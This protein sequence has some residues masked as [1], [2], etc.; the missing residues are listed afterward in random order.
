MEQNLTSAGTSRF[1][2]NTG[3]GT[4]FF[5]DIRRI[6]NALNFMT[7]RMAIFDELDEKSYISDAITYIYETVDKSRQTFV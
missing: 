7:L 5:N 6:E 4:D 1:Y 3:N 2:P